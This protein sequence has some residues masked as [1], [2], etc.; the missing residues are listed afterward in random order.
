M[1]A[2]ANACASASRVGRRG[3]RVSQRSGTGGGR[4]CTRSSSRNVDQDKKSFGETLFS[5]EDS[6]DAAEQDAL[7]EN[8]ARLSLDRL[9]V[10][11]NTGGTAP[12][13][14]P[15]ENPA[16]PD[17]AGSQRKNG[18]PSNALHCLDLSTRRAPLR[19]AALSAFLLC[20]FTIQSMLLDYNTAE[21]RR[22]RRLFPR[23]KKIKNKISWGGERCEPYNRGARQHKTSEM[24]SQQSTR[25]QVTT[26]LSAG[27]RLKS[28]APGSLPPQNHVVPTSPFSGYRRS[29]TIASYFS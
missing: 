4:L 21:Q 13:R 29:K 17:Q 7:R 19:H 9:R 27:F 14:L 2:L 10:S 1:H 20:C 5:F 6:A 23:L 3:R 22:Q 24:P 26:P 11:P 8:R 25:S 12:T 15:C 16:S 28:S 18:V